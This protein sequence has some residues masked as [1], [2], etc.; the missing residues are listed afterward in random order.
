M[1]AWLREPKIIKLHPSCR[2]ERTLL[3]NEK[4]VLWGK[5]HIQPQWDSNSC[6]SESE[7]PSAS[8]ASQ[9]QTQALGMNWSAGEVVSRLLQQQQGE[10]W[11]LAWEAALHQE[12]RCDEKALHWWF[13]H[14][15]QLYPVPW[16]L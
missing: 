6:P 15:P 13:L 11:P 7:S 1:L 4:E 2:R 16:L 10:D 5:G 12:A 9:P 3:H 8:K 14:H